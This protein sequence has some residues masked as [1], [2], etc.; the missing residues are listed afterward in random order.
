MTAVASFTDAWIETSWW[1][2]VHIGQRVASFTDAWIETKRLQGRRNHPWSH[3]LQMRG[4]KPVLSLQHTKGRLSH[5]L[6]MRGL[7]RFW[8]VDYSL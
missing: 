6:Q 8:F 1:C 4:L 5:L 7:K 2:M 3:L